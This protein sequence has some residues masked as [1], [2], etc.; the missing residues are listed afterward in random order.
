MEYMRYSSNWD[1]QTTCIFSYTGF[2]IFIY[3]RPY[4][5]SSFLLDFWKLSGTSRHS[6]PK[7]MKTAI[8][9]KS[10][11]TCTARFWAMNRA[12]YPLKV[13]TLTLWGS[14]ECRTPVY[15]CTH[16][17][18]G[19]GKCWRRTNYFWNWDSKR[20]HRFD[21]KHSSLLPIE[22]APHARRMRQPGPSS[23]VV[24]P[25]GRENP[26]ARDHEDRDLDGAQIRIYNDTCTHCWQ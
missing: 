24:L 14:Y 26:P 15:H 19:S 8:L 21:D 3:M 10:I 23:A 20:G 13:T 22:A 2:E 5:W 16:T 9:T 6:N 11:T 17:H 4:S 1:N 25:W 18:K 12:T 7:H